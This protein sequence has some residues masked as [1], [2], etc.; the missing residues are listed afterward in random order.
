MPTQGFAVLTLIALLP[1]IASAGEDTSAGRDLAE[2]LCSRCHSIGHTGKS[3]DPKAP[4]FRTLKELYPVEDLEE[5]LAEGL[6][7]GHPDMPEVQLPP[8]VIASFIAYLKT[9]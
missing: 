8:D 2:R 1:A 5:S 4:A 6:S 9:L 3:P 7:T